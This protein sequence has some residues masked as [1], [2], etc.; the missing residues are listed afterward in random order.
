MNVNMPSAGNVPRSLMSYAPPASPE[1]G[2]DTFDLAAGFLL[3]RRRIIMIVAISVLLTIAV[4]PIISGLSPRY[5]AES[6]LMIHPPL[7]AALA[8]DDTER[9][10]RLDIASEI[11]RLLSRRIADR[12]IRDQKLDER[13]EFNPALREAT[14]VSRLRG[15]LRSL[16][17]RGKPRP[18]NQSSVE[19]TIPGYYT[20]LTVQR[21]G[22]TNVVQIGF[23][24]QDP[25]LAAVVPN[26]LI[27]IYLKERNDAMRNRL[28]SAQTWIAQRI[29]EQRNR[30]KAA[31]DAA[32]SYGKDTGTISDGPQDEQAKAIVE[33]SQQ[34]A[35]I[36]QS[37]S[38]VKATITALKSA[39]NTSAGLEN[40]ILP[41]AIADFERDLRRQEH[42]LDRLLQVYGDNAQEVVALR[43]RILKTRSDLGVEVERYVQSQ[44]ARLAALDRQESVVDAALTIARQKL[45]GS[46]LEQTELTRLQHVADRE[47][48]SL[49][50]LESQRRTLAAEVA[51][52]G[53]EVEILS[54]ATMPIASQGRSRLFYLIGAMLASVCIAVT[55][56]FAR[57]LLDSSVRSHDQLADING[58]VPG[59]FIPLLSRKNGR[60]LPLFF[61][62]SQDS[63]FGEAIRTSVFALKQSNGGRLPESIAVT[64]AHGGEG[65]SLVA[66]SLAIELTA[67]G[68]KVLLV[69]GD[70]RC[71]NVGTF[72][73][74]G[75][76]QGLNEF[77]CGQADLPDVVHHHD[78]TG[79]DFIPRGSPSLDRRPHLAAMAEILKFA[80]AHGQIA[81]FDTA[82][83]LASTATGHLAS[84]AERTIMVVQWAKTSRRA[85]AYA[86]D[87]L[88]F[89][90]NSEIFVTINKVIPEEHKLYGYSDSEMY[91]KTLR[92]YHDINI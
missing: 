38:E 29:E 36:I 42:D 79:I 61:G 91:S 21:E 26:R 18:A 77:L 41:D 89:S 27:D 63:M 66:R 81:I 33:L 32:T 20:A 25:E 90:S 8:A 87:K 53:A 51:L 22:A 11:E 78:R 15:V 58:V 67:G 69:D 59:G 35:K 80:H 46:T 64:S 86:L 74:P 75:L 24:S 1:P 10:E 49:D 55:A 56:A 73:I 31:R 83:I 43:T 16:V 12:V 84:L 40:I 6:R 14:L 44:H 62:H 19:Q 45:S 2:P 47:Q 82:P 65:K 48:A 52:P 30:V 54:P 34:Q 68:Q 17:S 9:S 70:L 7:A 39:G 71:G 37:R 85:V 4:I 50:R 92:K 60:A 3:L 5:H 23:T 57:E 28:R 13:A 76:K 72:F 88:Q